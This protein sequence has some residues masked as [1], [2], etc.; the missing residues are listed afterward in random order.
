MGRAK[1]KLE[2]I[3]TERSR[4]TTFQKRKKGLKKKTYE[5][6]TL[7]GVD[8]CLI[9]LGPNQ[10]DRVVEPETWLENREDVLNI[11]DQFR[12]N[13]TVGPGKRHVDIPDLLEDQTKKVRFKLA[14]LR[15]WKD[16]DKYPT[17]DDR[18]NNFSKDQLMTL[19]ASLDSKLEL[20]KLMIDL[21][22]INHNPLDDVIGLIG[23]SVP[24]MNQNPPL[25]PP[26][27]VDFSNTSTMDDIHMQMQHHHRLS[28]DY[29]HLINGMDFVTNCYG[30]SNSI[31]PYHVPSMSSQI[32]YN[33]MLPTCNEKAIMLNNTEGGPVPCYISP[34]MQPMMHPYFAPSMHQINEFSDLQDYH[35]VLD[36]H[37]P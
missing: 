17:W 8:A 18:I 34:N 36:H 33:P 16:K 12:K 35:Q 31:M 9:I 14:E 1:V 32:Y 23:Y 7:C 22:E 3:A 6:S 10:G 26:P 5:F 2:L 13:C 25:L 30:A 11:I 15:Q 21:N 28:I 19:V 24:P 4:N 27:Y 20:V 37:Q 29:G